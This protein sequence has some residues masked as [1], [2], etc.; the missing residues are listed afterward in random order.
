MMFILAPRK[1]SY[2]KAKVYCHIRLLSFV[3]K[4]IQRLVA[5]HIRDNTLG[6]PL[7]LY[8]SAYKTGKSK[9]TA[10]YHVITHIQ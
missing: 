6:C 10:I 1:A 3:Q 9:E 2:T 4:T 8:Q 7:C 5:R